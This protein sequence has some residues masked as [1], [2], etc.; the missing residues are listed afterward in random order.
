VA[1]RAGKV[2]GEVTASGHEGEVRVQRWRWGVQAGTAVG[3][4]VATSR[5]SYRNLELVKQVD[6]ATT[7]L[8]AALATNDEVKE[9]VLTMRKAGSGQLDYFTLKL[10][11]A[12]V[13]AVEHSSDDTG[14]TLETVA[15]AFNK[16]ELEYRTQQQGGGLGASFVFQDELVSGD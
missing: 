6:S 2:K 1:M 12:R 16:V 3:S 9:A 5:R 15:I 8:L 11:A 10:S 14:E 4:T 7:A 13:T